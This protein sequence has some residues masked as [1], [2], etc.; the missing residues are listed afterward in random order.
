MLK[1]VNK[2]IIEIN[3]PSSEYFE[4]AIFFVRPSKNGAGMVDLKCDADL[5]LSE[6]EIKHLSDD[7]TKEN[8]LKKAAV[9][10]LCLGVGA[11]SSGLTLL[12]MGM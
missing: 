6:A 12:V 11:I 9:F 5:I 10:L 2:L 1:G 8:F 7:A 3:N 4:R